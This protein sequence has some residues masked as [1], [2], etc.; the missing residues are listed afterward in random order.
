[1]RGATLKPS[2]E[3][4]PRRAGPTEIITRTPFRVS[5]F[6]GGTDYPKWYQEHTV[7]SSRYQIDKYCYITCRTCA[8]LRAPLPH[9]LFAKSERRE[10]G[11]S[12]IPR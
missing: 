1:M 8:V 12:S 9:R 2:R 6:G 3:L 5:L 7:G 4:L 11:K 10:A